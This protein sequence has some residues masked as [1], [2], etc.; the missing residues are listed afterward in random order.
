MQ[1]NSLVSMLAWH[2]ST[3]DPWVQGMGLSSKLDEAGG[4]GGGGLQ[5]H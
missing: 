4:I 1:D 5:V 2:G 3:E